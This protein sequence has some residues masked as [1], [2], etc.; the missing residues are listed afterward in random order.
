MKETTGLEN[1]DE[2]LVLAPETTGAETSPSDDMPTEEAPAPT[3]RERI[4][5]REL[6]ECR[7]GNRK[8]FRMS[9]GTEQAVFYP[10]AVH[11][12]NQETGMY[13]NAGNTLVTEEDGKHFAGSTDRLIAHFSREAESSELFSVENGGYRVTVLKKTTQKKP[14]K[15]ILPTVLAKTPAEYREPDRLVF[16]DVKD[17]TDY[18][19]AVEGGG[20]KENII[21]RKKAQ[22]YR[23][24]FRL[25]C[26]NVIP[27][28]DHDTQ[29][30]AFIAD[31]SG[32]E[33][34]FIPAPFMTDANGV[35]STAVRYSIGKMQEGSVT[36]TVIADKEFMNAEERAFPVV[37]DP[38]IK[39]TGA[40][41]METYNWNQGNLYSNNT[42]HTIGSTGKGDGTCS[43]QRMYIH[44]NL[45]TLPRNPRIKK[46][47]LVFY[48]KEAA[49]F[50][51]SRPKFGLYRVIDSIQ[52]GN[53]TPRDTGVLIDL[54]AMQSAQNDPVCYTFDVTTLVDQ[55]IKGESTRQDLVL[56]M[57]DEG[58]DCENSITLYGSSAGA[59]YAP[60]FVVTYEPS[61][62]VNTAYR[63]HTHTLGRFGQGSIDLQCGN[64]MFESEDF[65]WG[66]NRMPV[67]I[68]HLYNSALA[69][70]RYTGDSS[71]SL[72]CANFSNM[73]VG[74][75]FRLNLMQG[76]VS[77][78][79]YV[80]GKQ[81]TGYIHTDENGEESYY[82]KTN[83]PVC[84]NDTEQC[85]Y[86]YEE[87]NGDGSYHPIER[88]LTRGGETHLFDTAG[89]LIRVT[90]AHNNHM[91]L[92]YS[93]AG[94][95]TSVTDGAGRVFSFSYNESSGTLSSVTAPDGTEISYA[96][97]GSYL[98]QITYPGNKKAVIAYTS[99]KPGSVTLYDGDT[100]SYRVAY[101]FSGDRLQSVSEYGME[102]GSEVRG[103]KSA[104]S[105]SA[106]SGRTVVTTTEPKDTEAGE[107]ADSVIKTVY[108]FDE[109]GN[110]VS[111]YMYTEETGNVGVSGG[112]SGIH[113]HGGDTGAGV[114]SNINNLLTGHGFETLDAWTGLGGNCQNISIESADW[115][116]DSKY[117]EKALRMC[118]VEEGATKNGVEQL[119]ATLPAGQYT[120]S[121]YLLIAASFKGGTT[122]GAYIRVV[123]TGGS[124]LAV[125]ERLTT[126]DR[127]YVRLI[128]PFTLASAQRVKVQILVDGAGTVYADGAQLENNP[129]ANAY[130]LLENGNFERG[131]SGWTIGNGISDCTTEKFNM[132]HSLAM[133][134]R[135]NSVRRASQTVYVKKDRS[136][137]ETFTLSGW[138]KGY[139]LPVHDRENVQQ[140]TFRLYAQI[141]YY[142]VKYK[143]YGT[144]TF[145]AD[146]SPRTEDWQFASVQFSKSKFR[147]IRNLTVRCEYS[148][149]EGTAYF[150]DIQLT[151][152]SMEKG[153]SATD[154]VLESNGVDDAGQT[155][156]ADTVPTFRES[157][158]T[159]GNALTETTFTDGEFG[160]IYRAFQY[161]ADRAGISGNDAG[162]DLIEETDARGNKTAYTV[163]ARTSRNTEVVDRLGNKTVYEYDASGR[164]TKVTGKN[165]NGTAL[166][167]VSYAYDAFDNLTE[168]VRGDGL[169]YALAYNEFHNLESI[170]I[171]GKTEQLIR[172]TYKA[173]NGRLKQMTYANGDKMFAKYNSIGHMVDEKWQNSTGNDIAH[174]KYVYDGQG[175]IV[176][177]IDI[178]SKKEYNYQYEEGRIVR[179]TEATI[180]LSGEIVTSKNV[181]STIEYEYDSNGNLLSKKIGDKDGAICSCSY[182][183]N[184]TEDEVARIQIGS[185]TVT[186]HSKTDKFL[187]KVF[188]ELETGTTFVSRQFHYLSGSVT[189]RH[190]LAEKLRSTAT[191][192]LVSEIVFSNDRTISYQYDAEDRIVRVNDSVSGVCDYTYNALNLLESET[193][194]GE[195]T[196][197]LYDGYGNI[198]EKGIIDETGE[199]AEATK[200][201]YGYQN[202]TWKDLLTSYNGQA[203]VYDAQGNPV[204]YLG[205]SLTW[206]KGRQLKR[207]DNNN[208]A[209]NAN[210]VRISKT[211]NGVRH[212]YCLEGTKIVCEKW[213]SNVLIPLYDN[214]DIVC[215]IVYN[216]IPYYFHRNLQDDII[217]IV[218]K[219]GSTVAR[220]TYDAWGACISVSGNNGIATINPFRYRGYYCDVETGYYYLQTRYYDPT[221]GRFLNSDDT[222]YL[223]TTDSAV[224]FN[225][226]SYCDNNPVNRSDVNGHSWISDRFNDVKNAAKKITKAVSNTVQKVASAAK[227]VTTAVKNVVVDTAQKTATAVTNTTRSLVTTVS[228][229]AKD[230]VDW[231]KN[232][233]NDIAKGVK[234]VSTKA[235]E[236]VVEA[237]NWT[238]KKAIPVVG[239]FFSETVWKKWIVGG[240][241]ETFCKDWVWETFCK[242]WVWETF[243]KDWVWETFCKKQ[244]WQTVILGTWH[245]INPWLMD[246]IT[247]VSSGKNNLI[248]IVS[249]EQ[250]NKNLLH[251]SKEIASKTW[252][253]K[254]L[255]IYCQGYMSSYSANPADYNKY[256]RVYDE[257]I[258]LKCC[259]D[260]DLADKGCGLV[261][262]YNI[263]VL[264]GNYIDMRSI[265][266]WFEQNKGF[267]LNAVF[268]VNPNIIQNFFN[269]INVNANGF[270]DLT[271]LEGTRT[272]SGLYIV[273]QWNNA[274]DIAQGAHFYAVK[275]SAGQLI[276]YNGA[277]NYSSSLS[278]KYADF[279]SML[280]Y[281][282]GGSFIYGYKIG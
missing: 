79:F 80:D 169:Q 154:F 247:K 7:T 14:G 202:G 83:K 217:A 17:G 239:N 122:P 35:V 91:N 108:T 50:E 174:Y 192:Q 205:H 244:V 114:V 224:G 165:Q 44:L 213:G 187:R 258:L 75:G 248:T 46:A 131:T 238:T 188:D 69:A 66:G 136:V 254:R 207:I 141:N 103:V 123:S 95:L 236:A 115:S 177:S 269:S 51:K 246:T 271:L 77:G 55:I 228:G 62:A 12:F 70:Y 270:S 63:S 198:L 164:T 241:W 140:P 225:L 138:A 41:A 132:S 260:K 178:L 6:P 129:Y 250:S 279:A 158:D 168:I 230:A 151:R 38:Q 233:I 58:D 94:R 209:Y 155:D 45:P 13:E 264:S 52:T 22:T 33:I 119:T 166:A 194:E 176:R 144:E 8:I 195:T 71:I 190:Q 219:T 56:R 37:I 105:Y 1:E 252:A 234:N 93:S 212:T 120:F 200:V 262:V 220:Y 96:Y 88:T 179:A 185:S 162:N 135:P 48:R 160:T 111:E 25:V 3:H 266:Y 73:Q 106:A 100:C 167:N 11:V 173:G 85:D 153:L 101:A 253:T 171:H 54:A 182:E 282:N 156:T 36:L 110:T 19:Y 256:G 92:T 193:I 184:E 265:I 191:T 196:K 229:V 161:N 263:G 152:D 34:F 134:G 251:N 216:G 89:R 275:E 235:K 130:N 67:T 82:R 9:D 113:P 121:A 278:K 57:I 227:T 24:A 175:N 150:D 280:S 112:G 261:A 163:D 128:V 59:N 133:S 145:S 5:M 98:T 231:T 272:N 214:E 240:V 23:Y 281:K 87:V 273:C 32:E 242:D 186:A 20:V 245:K 78:D 117:G 267:V 107:T 26:E 65:A 183:I 68:K 99:N 116:A 142:D 172:Y 189:G 21:V 206:E 149:N 221:T 27:V 146:F 64:L 215:G 268:G 31:N 259:N 143:E 47:E 276:P 102:N 139:G 249:I 208:Y 126:F 255:P 203:I 127:E 97:S 274:T 180:T 201:S 60:Q 148:Y 204:T 104:Y 137:R 157:E 211:V 43:V 76:M 118:S 61:Y 86:L 53:Y 218:D 72:R 18:T 29:R 81:Y 30:I 222:K 74:N 243:C 232:K 49:L 42:A 90:D 109:D 277:G 181:I 40:T 39:L 10:E 125:S 226:F 199:I 159:Y 147:Q 84:K 197:Y 170:G 124:V 223:G 237:W 257:A 15:G 2:A 28:V 210:G 16:A 4:R